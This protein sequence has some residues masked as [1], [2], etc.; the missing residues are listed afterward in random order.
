MVTSVQSN[1]VRKRVQDGTPVRKYHQGPQK[2]TTGDAMVYR[3]YYRAKT[4]GRESKRVTF[5]Y[6]S[7]WGTPKKD[8]IKDGG[9]LFTIIT[10]VGV[11]LVNGS[12]QLGEN[13]R[14]PS[15]Y[16]SNCLDGFQKENLGGG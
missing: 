8:H 7:S 1:R 6:M 3:I 16:F 15:L 14:R 12:G 2:T 9:T 13:L 10:K 4:L 11:G 5:R